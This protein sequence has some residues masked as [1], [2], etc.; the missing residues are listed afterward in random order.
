MLSEIIY[1][2]VLSKLE[3]DTQVTV[4]WKFKQNIRL[5]IVINF[6]ENLLSSNIASCSYPA[7]KGKFHEIFPTCELLLI[8]W[9]FQVSSF[10]SGNM[11]MTG[12]AREKPNIV[13][14]TIIFLC[15]VFFDS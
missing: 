4:T 6:P 11:M 15:V 5:A 7:E 2:P 1:I 10:Y 14:S 9:H 3:Q 8:T 12:L 13:S